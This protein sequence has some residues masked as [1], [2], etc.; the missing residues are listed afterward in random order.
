MNKHQ[1]IVYAQ[2]ADESTPETWANEEEKLLI[3]EGPDT[4]GNPDAPPVNYS[5][6]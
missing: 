3:K 4:S 5:Y 1:N 2:T 6:R